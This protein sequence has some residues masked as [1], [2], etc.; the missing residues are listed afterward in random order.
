MKFLAIDY[1]L[2]RC[3][4]AVSDSGGAFAFPRCTLQRETKKQ[5]FSDLLALIAREGAE[6][7]V[8]GL[9]LHTDGTPCLATTHVKHF[10]DSLRRRTELPI[11]LM[12]EVLSS[13]EAESELNAMGMKAPKIKQ[14]LDQQAAVLI[15]ETF[16]SQPA[17]KRITA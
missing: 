3:G 1:G 11:F 13:C 10:V 12:N 14:V 7:I 16:L 9:P 6:A 5:F 17:E 15:L 4:I 2:K 8:V